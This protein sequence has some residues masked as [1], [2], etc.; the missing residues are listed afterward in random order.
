VPASR[1]LRRRARAMVGPIEFPLL[2]R[3]SRTHRNR[4]RAGTTSRGDLIS[5]ATSANAATSQAFA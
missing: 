2:V 1:L 4:L 3:L 5:L